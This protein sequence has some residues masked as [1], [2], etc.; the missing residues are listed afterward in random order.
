MRLL[1]FLHAIRWNGKSLFVFFP[2]VYIYSLSV[3]IPIFPDADQP[4]NKL[5]PRFDQKSSLPPTMYGAP[6]LNYHLETAFFE[7]RQDPGINSVADPDHGAH[8]QSI[9][10][11]PHDPF[12]TGI[13]Y[14]R[15]DV[16][17]T[18]IQ[19]EQILWLREYYPIVSLDYRIQGSGCEE[20]TGERAEHYRRSSRWP[21]IALHVATTG[22]CEIYFRTD[23]PIFF[24]AQIV[25]LA[26][27][28]FLENEKNEQI[29]NVAY[30]SVLGVLFFYNLILWVLMRHRI[31]ASYLLL[32]G[33]TFV[34]FFYM[35]G[36]T[37]YLDL[38]FVLDKIIVSFSYFWVLAL[39][40]FLFQAIP[41]AKGGLIE[42]L[43]MFV[44]YAFIA[45]G[46]IAVPFMHYLTAMAPL[47]LILPVVPILAL[48][49]PAYHTWKGVRSAKL[50]LIA[51]IIYLILA[52]L[53]N[54]MD[55]AGFGPDYY[56]YVVYLQ[57]A[58]SLSEMVL[59]SLLV[60]DRFIQFQRGKEAADRALLESKESALVQMKKLDQ[61]KDRFLANTSHEL[62][63][64]VHGILGL[65]EQLQDELKQKDHF[66]SA[67]NDLSLI[68]K[69]ARR[70]SRLIDDL[71]DFSRMQNHDLVM[72][73]QVVHL[74]S[75]AA[76]V[77][78]LHRKQAEEKNIMVLLA[79]PDGEDIPE[80]VFL[81]VDPDRLEQILHNLL[82]NAIRNAPV[83]SVVRFEYEPCRNDDGMAQISI[84]NEGPS[85]DPALKEEIFKPFTQL[86]KNPSGLGL[87]LAIV[88]ELALLN[89]GEAFLMDASSGVR[90]GVILPQADQRMQ[91][92]KK[93][94][95]YTISSTDETGEEEDRF[96]YSVSSFQAEELETEST[97]KST[98]NSDFASIRVLIV[99]DDPISLGLLSRVI[100]TSGF[101]VVS[102]ESGEEALNVLREQSPPVEIA[103]IDVMLPGMSGL[104]LSQEIRKDYSHSELP[105]LMITARN[106]PEDLASGMN[107][108][109]TEFLYRP[110]EKVEVLSRIKNLAERIRM[111]KHSS[112][113]TGTLNK[114]FKNEVE[115]IYRN[116]HDHIGARF[117][118][119]QIRL[120]DLRE[121]YLSHHSFDGARPLVESD[122]SVVLE[123]IESLD[124]TT[125]SAIRIFREQIQDME[126][127]AEF[128]EDLTMGLQLF[129]HSQYEAAKREVH[130]EISDLFS[131][132]SSEENRAR[133][134]ST[135]FP[136]VREITTN[137]L[138]YGFGPSRWT[139]QVMENHPD[140]QGDAMHIEFSAST[141][142]NNHR[143]S[144]SGE[145]GFGSSNIQHRIEQAGG[146]VHYSIDEQKRFHLKI[147]LPL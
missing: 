66:R 126:A 1:R 76:G 83:G 22:R 40:P 104:D 136:V 138:K 141:T 5:A 6:L 21:L 52:F 59:F 113:L 47:Y 107:A 131:R 15:L 39:I 140:F 133:H 115:Q 84:A 108:G 109:A 16:R 89:G 127:I 53:S 81:H 134:A 45:Y 130:I 96:E 14:Y 97:G 93:V 143:P 24:I 110:F 31:F 144:V 43:A 54:F 61:L 145:R 34:Y 132:K 51:Y 10:V 41:E 19:G 17:E 112:D 50:F 95:H 117:V 129:L 98:A 46:I 146:V 70:L 128:T 72:E 13:H 120:E 135:L 69:T 48:A 105:I 58:G 71:L 7:E 26:P 2:F 37:A 80:D 25:S 33:S 75:Y 142:Y 20:Q 28:L 90:I 99:D 56:Q 101:S 102:V 68:Q 88:R 137:D 94:S 62:R 4:A 124:E 86:E 55:I 63:T 42:R 114:Q 85:I 116:L 18:G 77:V 79:T 82:F 30:L 74:K 78:S 92:E 91:E 35:T 100:G 12:H 36:F 118:E 111:Q 73:K 38:P 121:Q 49:L 60:S 67:L 44:F 147:A 27:H 103:V 11:Q 8:F 125:A 29:M 119:L 65:A 32:L 9:D 57:Q 3:T 122:P 123:K 139:F 23:S 64:P 87:G 106:R